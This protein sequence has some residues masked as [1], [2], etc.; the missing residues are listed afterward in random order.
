M[1]KVSKVSKAIKPVLKVVS[2]LNAVVESNQ[3]KIHRAG[4]TIAACR[5]SIMEYTAETNRA[6]TLL[7]A[8]AVFQE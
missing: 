1:T 6:N 4:E 2:D 7:E 8:L 3:A 5:T